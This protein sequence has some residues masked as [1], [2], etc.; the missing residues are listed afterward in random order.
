[1]SFVHVDGTQ[2]EDAMLEVAK[3]QEPLHVK[4]TSTGII[5]GHDVKDYPKVPPDPKVHPKFKSMVS[6]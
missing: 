3:L 1:M 2:D 4:T 5:V 6:W